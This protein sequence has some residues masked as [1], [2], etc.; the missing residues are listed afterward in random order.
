MH[1]AGLKLKPIL[2]VF[3]FF[4]PFFYKKNYQKKGVYT[5]L[6]VGRLVEISVVVD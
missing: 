3:Y 5:S 1:E 2:F 6:K 4:T